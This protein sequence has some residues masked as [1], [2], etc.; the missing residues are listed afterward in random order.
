[1]GNSVIRP[2]PR[3][4]ALGMI[5]DL[6]KS[7]SGAMDIKSPSYKPGDMHLPIGSLLGLDSL[8]NVANHASY[9]DS[10][11]VEANGV[12]NSPFPTFKAGRGE[13]LRD[14]AL[15]ALPAAPVAARGAKM[16]GMGALSELNRAYH[17]GQGPLADLLGAAKPAF[18]VKPKGGNWNEK[19]L[20]EFVNNSL[21]SAGDAGASPL[22]PETVNWANT[23][24]KKH[25]KNYIGTEHDPMI[26]L[27]SDNM[28]IPQAQ[29]IDSTFDHGVE[30]GPLKEF[31]NNN[32]ESRGLATLPP[33]EHI[34]DSLVDAKSVGDFTKSTRV[35]DMPSDFVSSIVGGRNGRMLAIHGDEAIVEPLGNGEYDLHPSNHNPGYE[36]WMEKA[37]PSTPIY[38]MKP[39]WGGDPHGFDK[40]LAHVDQTGLGP[41]DL[42]RY[43]VDLAARNIAKERQAQ[44]KLVADQGLN[45]APTVVKPYDDGSQWVKLDKPGQFASESDMMSHSVRGYEPPGL[46]GPDGD[47]GGDAR[48]GV[49]TGGWKGIQDGTAQVHSL[50]G[51][52]GKSIATV[53]SENQVIDPTTQ[54]LKTISPQLRERLLA[55]MI[56]PE[57]KAYAA[58]G[59][60]AHVIPI[61]DTGHWEIVPPPRPIVTQIKGA[62]NRSIIDP[63]AKN[64]ILDFLNTQHK[65][66]KIQQTDMANNDIIDM[67]SIRG[68][69]ADQPDYLKMLDDHAQGRR[70]IHGADADELWRQH[71]GET[72]PLV[73]FED[74]TNDGDPI[75]GMPGRFWGD[76]L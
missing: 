74:G 22:R 64:K 35:K 11:F 63:E 38:S 32:V 23:V 27:G 30:Q 9:G 19:S 50:R 28:H 54:T 68:G 70:F 48:Y 56:P 37:D 39:S 8:S 62:N 2:T 59:E 41:E 69:Y 12:T 24:L 47:L 7:A 72:R 4:G 43:P 60:D 53:E 36:S 25:L 17:T 46:R 3:N 13:E 67:N 58:H 15:A 33:W 10:P 66:S 40:I 73:G 45:P 42:Q 75:P 1:M 76:G 52:D 61:G 16:A 49:G 65:D 29:L 71:T 5:A 34:G 31:Q 26:A 18:A 55:D 21:A 51:P 44:M 6:L 14:A 20:D 57:A